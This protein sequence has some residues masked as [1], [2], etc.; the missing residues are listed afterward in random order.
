MR[1]WPASARPQPAA[2]RGEPGIALAGRLTGAWRRSSRARLT[3][4]SAD[5]VL[6]RARETLRSVVS[7]SSGGHQESHRDCRCH[8]ERA[9]VGGRRFLLQAVA[10]NVSGKPPRCPHIHSSES[11]Y[12]DSPCPA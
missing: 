5:V 7:V 1:P 9:E 10:L 11:S 2:G 8:D 12:L 3:C 6:A 4:E